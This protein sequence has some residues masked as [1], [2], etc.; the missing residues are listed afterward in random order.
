MLLARHAQRV[1]ANRSLNRAL[2]LSLSL[3]LCL[4]LRV[5]CSHGQSS[6]KVRLC[7]V[8]AGP[9]DFAPCVFALA[10][11]VGKLDESCHV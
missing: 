7:C 6:A 4:S 5:S 3:S 2:A 10:E 11:A 9:A 8:F 1:L